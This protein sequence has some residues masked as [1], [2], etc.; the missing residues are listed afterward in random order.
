MN[1]NDNKQVTAG[2]DEAPVK[3]KLSD[4]VAAM[5]AGAIELDCKAVLAFCD[6][7]GSCSVLD[8]NLLSFGKKSDVSLMMVHLGVPALMKGAMARHPRCSSA[9][10]EAACRSE[11]GG[12]ADALIGAIFGKGDNNEEEGED[13][14]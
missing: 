6:E 9:L 10:V 12:F 13:N 1:K 4:I 14:E 11:R 2:A 8:F 5:R 3:L 7:E